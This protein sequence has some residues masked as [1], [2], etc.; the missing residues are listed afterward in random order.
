MRAVV[1][2]WELLSVSESYSVSLWELLSISESCC[3]SLKA[4]VSL[5]ELLSQ[6]LYWQFTNFYLHIDNAFSFMAKHLYASTW[7]ISSTNWLAAGWKFVWHMS[8]CK[9]YFCAGNNMK[10]RQLKLHTLSCVLLK[11]LLARR[12]RN[13]TVFNHTKDRSLDSNPECS[14]GYIR[15][16]ATLT[17]TCVWFYGMHSYYTVSSHEKRRGTCIQAHDV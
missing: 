12:R 10:W 9:E 15:D 4:V 6:L 2:L 3:Q 8:V 11:T 5:W 16:Y 17:C 1:S 13:A 7:R 14:S